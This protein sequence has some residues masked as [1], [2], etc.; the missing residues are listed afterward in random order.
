MGVAEADTVRCYEMDFI[1]S[2]TTCCATDVG[3]RMPRFMQYCSM[4]AFGVLPY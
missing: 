3:S 1:R 4:W 2:S